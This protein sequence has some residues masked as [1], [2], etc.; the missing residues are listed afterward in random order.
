MANSEQLDGD[1]AAKT[2]ARTAARLSV[3]PAD[4]DAGPAGRPKFPRDNGFQAEL[5]LRV[6]G[7]FRATG[8]RERDCWQMYLKTAVIL[9]WCAVSYAL[10][11]FVTR[12]WWQALPPAILL[13]AGLGAVGFSIQHDGGHRAYSRRRWVNKLAAWSLDLMGASSY[14]WHW[15]HHIFH[16]TY[17]NV[18]GVDS[19]IELGAI[20]R[21]SP[22]QPRRWFHRWQHLYLWPLYGLMA[23]RWHLWG[24]FKDAITGWMGPHRI[25]RPSGW[26]L[27]VFLVGKIWSIGLLLVLPMLFHPVWAVLVFYLI[28]TAVLGVIMSVVFQLAHCVEEADFPLPDPRTQR[29]ASAWAVHQA[30]TTVDFARRSRVLSWY[31]G[32]LNFQIEHH[33]F[34]HVCHVHYPALSEIV[35]ATCRE[36]GVRYSAHCTLWAGLTSHYR[37]LRRMG[38]PVVA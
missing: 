37:W 29:M 3:A 38:L 14:L 20:V 27:A 11:V 26:D 6:A 2:S 34:P 19:D 12:T 25:P 4:T 31:L 10:L 17:S 35:E 32:G 5:G 22:H 7:Y 28:V 16:H 23:G 21:V 13:A 36:Y 9:V 8:R 15:K 30:E 33:L 18:S 1:L 24:D